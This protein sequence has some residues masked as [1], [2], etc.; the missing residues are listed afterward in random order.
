VL[1][2]PQASPLLVVDQ[3]PVLVAV[4]EGLLDDV[5]LHRIAEAQE[6]LIA[7]VHARLPDL[8]ALIMCGKPFSDD[9]HA[10]LVRVA[11]E[12]VSPLRAADI[13]AEEAFDA[14]D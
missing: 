5:P 8:A 6:L 7:G 2:Q 1:K 10:N 12:I 14:G 4:V 9:A 11:D 13:D 3:V